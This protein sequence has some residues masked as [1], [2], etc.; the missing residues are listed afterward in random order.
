MN[1]EIE[2]CYWETEENVISLQLIAKKEDLTDIKQLLGNTQL[3]ASG[4]DYGRGK[5][6]V[7]YRKLFREQQGMKNF[8]SELK[9]KITSLKEV[10]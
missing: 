7:I 10:I 8:L 4:T 1:N 3:L 5:E 9:R 2:A 6:I